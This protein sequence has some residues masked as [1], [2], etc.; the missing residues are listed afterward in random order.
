MEAGPI[1]DVQGG[2]QHKPRNEPAA[3][4]GNTFDEAVPGQNNQ[5]QTQR[6]RRAGDEDE[7]RDARHD[8]KDAGVGRTQPKKQRQPDQKEDGWKGGR[9]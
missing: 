5:P 7:G 6:Q 4:A 2:E 3:Q 8:E 9:L 1:A